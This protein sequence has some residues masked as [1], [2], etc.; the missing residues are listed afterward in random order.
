MMVDLGILCQVSSISFYG[1]NFQKYLNLNIKK[2]FR[3]DLKIKRHNEYI[4]LSE[5]GEG[6][7]KERPEVGTLKY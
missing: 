2:Q 6:L 5:G 7:L 4:I 1:K 3:S